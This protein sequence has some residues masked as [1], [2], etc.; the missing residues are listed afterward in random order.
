MG[1]KYPRAHICLMLMTKRFWEIDFARGLAVVLMVLFNY[2]FALDYLQIYKITDGWVFWWLFP[3]IVAGTFI[4]LAGLSLTISYSKNKGWRKHAKR[5]LKIFGCG[6]LITFVTLIALP[7][8]AIL[9]GILHLIGIS[10]IFGIF[11]IRFRK[12]NLL[13]GVALIAVGFYLESFI[14]GFPW[15]LWLGFVP[16]GFYTLDYF[17][18]MPWFGV[19]LLGIYF[20]NRFYKNGKTRIKQ[21][22]LIG[23]ILFCFL[24]RHSLLIYL[25]HQ[26]ILIAAL[27]L[28]GLL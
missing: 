18:M 2:A 16:Q 13:L 26:P 5:G 10:I 14:F 12:L 3:R 22:P 23:S 11:F 21:K 28:I 20:G 9:F 24:G 1:D 7:G 25:V 17:P 6:L 15:L 4:F 27:H 19:F 8:G